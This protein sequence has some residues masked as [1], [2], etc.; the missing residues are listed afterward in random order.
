MSEQ[1]NRARLLEFIREVRFWLRFMQKYV[2]DDREGAYIAL[3]SIEDELRRVKRNLYGNMMVVEIDLFDSADYEELIKDVVSLL[4]RDGYIRIRYVPNWDVEVTTEGYS[5]N[6]VK[7][8]LMNYMAK[9]KTGDRIL[10]IELAVL[11]LA[12]NMDMKIIKFVNEAL[13]IDLG[14]NW[15]L[16]R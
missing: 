9:Y 8:D 11:D 13:G 6:E 15:V 14:I 5:V 4:S 10:A 7:N 1:I 12:K 16:L 2:E 3:T